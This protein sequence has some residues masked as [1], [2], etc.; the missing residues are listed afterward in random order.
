MSLKAAETH[1]GTA[2]LLVDR[3]GLAG[4]GVVPGLHLFQANLISFALGQ[5]PLGFA[6]ELAALAAVLGAMEAI[7][8]E[9]VFHHEL[10]SCSYFK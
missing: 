9:D 1:H 7:A 5:I 6:L 10:D 4:H 3:L 8:A 2:T